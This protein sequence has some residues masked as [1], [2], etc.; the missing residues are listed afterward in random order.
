[1]SELPAVG[2]RVSLRYRLLAGSAKPLT[3]VIGHVERISPHGRR[4]HQVR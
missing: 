2:T 4:A 1:M 3:D